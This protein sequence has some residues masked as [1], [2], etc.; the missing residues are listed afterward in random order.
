[1]NAIP[2]TEALAA[3]EGIL[4]DAY[5]TMDGPQQLDAVIVAT[6]RMGVYSDLGTKFTPTKILV[7][8]LREQLVAR[9]PDDFCKCVEGLY[10]DLP[11]C[12][13]LRLWVQQ[14]LPDSFALVGQDVFEREKGPYLE[15]RTAGRQRLV[16]SGFNALMQ[17]RGQ[18]FIAAEIDNFRGKLTDATQ[19]LQLLNGYKQLHDN[20]HHI[21]NQALA[22]FSR[23]LLKARD[24]ERDGAD[25]FDDFDVQEIA[26]L[27]AMVEAQIPKGEA[28]MRMF[29][30][31]EVAAEEQ[32]Q[33]ML[34]MLGLAVAAL[35]TGDLADPATLRTVVSELRGVLRMHLPRLNKNLT[36]AARA[37]PFV[38]LS[39]LLRRAADRAEAEGS[40]LEARLEDAAL[41]LDE[42]G[43]R[44]KQMTSAH[45]IWQDID[46][47]LWLIEMIVKR[48]QDRDFRLELV[49]TWRNALTRVDALEALDPDGVQLLRNAAAAFQAQLNGETPDPARLSSAF[50]VYAGQVR[51]RFYMVDTALFSE[52]AA[53]AKLEPT[54]RA[55]SEGGN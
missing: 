20:L 6:V 43:A 3:L 32:R 27:G 33:R 17:A 19:Q 29:F 4:V 55:L 21:Q 18:S 50:H 34:P 11:G 37:I 41:A 51:L 28:T 10:R 48:A 39:R 7:H 5:G 52:C 16:I 36:D 31:D 45:G 24:E 46:N 47:A 49:G 44:L 15:A 13:P 30:D 54:L 12:E 23:I 14:H 42:T 8:G 9:G 26:E 35:K 2:P 22:R 53:I 40:P 25:R 38:D 1:M